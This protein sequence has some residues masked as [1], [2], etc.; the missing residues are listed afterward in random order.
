LLDLVEKYYVPDLRQH[1]AVKVVGT[2]VTNEDFVMA[3]QGNAYGS[4]MTPEQLTV[5]RLRATTP[6][7]NFFWCNASSGY[8]G[9]YGTVGTGMQLYMQLTGDVFFDG[10]KSPS[11]EQVIREVRARLHGKSAA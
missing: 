9:L 3:P 2:T 5:G 10:S 8:A 11:D 7:K 1:I 6:W 4:H